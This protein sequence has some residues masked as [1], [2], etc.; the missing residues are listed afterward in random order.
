M[1]SLQMLSPDDFLS[2]NPGRALGMVQQCFLSAVTPRTTGFAEAAE[3]IP[4]LWGTKSGQQ[5]PAGEK[6]TFRLPKDQT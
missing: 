2:H 5:N 3:V 1:P 6:M 4:R